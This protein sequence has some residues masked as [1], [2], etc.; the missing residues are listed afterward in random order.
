M[1]KTSDEIRY[2]GPCKQTTRHERDSK[3]GFLVCQRCGKK[4]YPVKK[5]AK[6]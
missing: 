3:D 5:K 1:G 2:C 6:R 4:K